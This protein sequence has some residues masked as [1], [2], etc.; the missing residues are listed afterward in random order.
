ME[1]PFLELVAEIALEVQAAMPPALRAW[2]PLLFP[3]LLVV[4][5]V[6][7]VAVWTC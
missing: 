5:I 6:A 7:W 3:A 2:F 4:G 1:H